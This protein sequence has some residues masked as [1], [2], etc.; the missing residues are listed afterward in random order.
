M[1][2]LRDLARHLGLS[3]TQVSRAL[4]GH[5][6]VSAATRARVAEAARARGYRPNLSAR[7]L[8]TGRSGMLGLVLSGVPGEDEHAQFVQIVGGLSLHLGRLGRPFVLHVADP[9]EDAV[10]VYRRLV[11]GRAIDG[12]VLLD[13]AERDRRLRF[14]RGAGVPFVVH[15]RVAGPADYPFYDIDNEA[16]GRRLTARVLQAGHE[17]VAFLNGPRGQGYAEARARG[18]RAAMAEAGHAPVHRFAAMTEGQGMLAVA[19]L[20][21][22]DPPSALVCGS[23]RVARGAVRMLGA[24]GLSVPGDVSVVAHDDGLPGLGPQGFEP[25]LT[26]TRSPLSEAWPHLARLLVAAEAGEPATGLQVLGEVALREGGSVGPLR[27]RPD[28]PS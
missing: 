16:V 10:E 26:V 5:G 4:N 6:D 11:E 23:M 18:F 27:R 15:G 8:A 19:E 2:T 3:V 9:G 24:L 25:V 14:L 21:R 28:R 1:P 22:R 13:P 7:R 17:R 20:W 12:F